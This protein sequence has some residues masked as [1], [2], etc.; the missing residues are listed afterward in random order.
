[1]PVGNITNFISSF[2]NEELSR[3]CYFTV[4]IIS[5][6]SINSNIERNV[7]FRCESA[8]LPGRT[9]SLVDQKTYGPI[10]QYPI[11]SAY[12][13][14]TLSFICSGNME[15]K[16]YFETWMNIISYSIPSYSKLPPKS[17]SV[18]FDFNYK[19]NYVTDIII[20]QHNLSG[21][22]IYRSIL[23]DAFPVECHSIPLNWSQANDYNRVIVTFAYRYAFGESDKAKLNAT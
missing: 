6:N 10:E 11:Q 1:M 20:N 16:V 3:P 5:P 13:K 17:V 15:E 4:N 9:F 22:I 23:V 2:K 7:V 8:E 19:K 14:S 12:N 18:K 21:E